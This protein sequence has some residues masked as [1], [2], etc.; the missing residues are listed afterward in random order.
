MQCVTCRKELVTE[1]STGAQRQDRREK[2]NGSHASAPRLLCDARG[3]D[4][5]VIQATTLSYPHKRAFQEQSE[6]GIRRQEP[7]LPTPA[8]PQE[9][10]EWPNNSA[11]NLRAILV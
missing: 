8:P 2:C 10:R 1:Q 6:R 3:V 4:T 11:R 9:F 5:Y 7:S